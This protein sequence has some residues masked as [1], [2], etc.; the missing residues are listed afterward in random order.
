[1][2]VTK[3]QFFKSSKQSADVKAQQTN[4]VVRDILDAEIAERLKKTEKLRALRLATPV[5][6]P[7][8]K[9]KTGS[10]SS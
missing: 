2:T 8:P 4:K 5:E 10:R 3:D 1:M 7:K 6:E 9:K